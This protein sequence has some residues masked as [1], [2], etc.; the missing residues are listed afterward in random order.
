[1]AKDG[2]VCFH[3]RLFANPLK[4]QKCTTEPVMPLDGTNKDVSATCTHGKHAFITCK[5]LQLTCKAMIMVLYNP[6]I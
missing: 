1:M 4:P 5:I 3:R 6:I 2:Q